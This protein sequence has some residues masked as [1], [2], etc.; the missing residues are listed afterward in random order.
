MV[1]NMNSPENINALT[2]EQE[3]E[4]SL[5]L[6]NE[7]V[8]KSFKLPPNSPAPFSEINAKLKE[9]KPKKKEPENKNQ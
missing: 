2:I 5:K 7:E 3:D 9:E 8:I 6:T 1:D 4:E